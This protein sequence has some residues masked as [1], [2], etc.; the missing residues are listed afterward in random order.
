LGSVCQLVSH[1]IGLFVAS[2]SL[3][4]FLLKVD[5]FFLS[6]FGEVYSGQECFARGFAM[7]PPGSF[8][9]CGHWRCLVIC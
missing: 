1:F 3:S 9:Y 6:H 4:S 7:L 2:G 5:A 8:R